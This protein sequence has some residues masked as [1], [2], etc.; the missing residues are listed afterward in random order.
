MQHSGNP[1]SSY[2]PKY[3]AQI[4][5]LM[6]NNDLKP[7]KLADPK[8]FD[9]LIKQPKKVRLRQA[10]PEKEL[11]KTET[12]A[13]LWLESKE[14]ATEA[15]GLTLKLGNGTVYTPDLIHLH[16]ITHKITAYEVKGKHAWDD[17]IVK[18][19]VA[20]SKYRAITFILVWRENRRAPFQEQLMHP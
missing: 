15:H 19:K 18:V 16:P 13:K 2:H 3:Q 11:N 8:T 6:A 17:A 20:A 5:Q 12:A 10:N 9:D 4:A 1:V 7:S 14:I